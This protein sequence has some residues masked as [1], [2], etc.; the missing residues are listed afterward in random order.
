MTLQELSATVK[1]N[2]IS[3][4]MISAMV[5]FISPRGNDLV[6]TGSAHHSEAVWSNAGRGG[7]YL[8][9]CRVPSYLAGGKGLGRSTSC[10]VTY[11]TL[12][13]RD[14]LSWN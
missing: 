10:Y 4:K 8:L 9:T 12:C 3:A 13:Y 14:W 2:F 5:E 7:S 6:L 11:E 1:I